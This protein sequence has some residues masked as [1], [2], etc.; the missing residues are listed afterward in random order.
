M[1]NK[2]K[3][4]N[5][6]CMLGR[7]DGSEVMFRV[8]KNEA[9]YSD[10]DENFG[11]SY[12]ADMTEQEAPGTRICFSECEELLLG[13]YRVLHQPSEMPEFLVRAKKLLKVEDKNAT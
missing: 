11:F 12:E 8:F 9:E 4:F 6:S 10:W 3:E 5:I 13:L 1:T 7:G 2:N